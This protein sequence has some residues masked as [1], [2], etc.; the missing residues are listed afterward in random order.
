MKL[1]TGVL[2]LALGLH[3]AV[4]LE[5]A[6]KVQASSRSAALSFFGLDTEGTGRETRTLLRSGS[7]VT[8]QSGGTA[9]KFMKAIAGGHSAD[10]TLK[11][12]KGAEL[13]WQLS[14]SEGRLKCRFESR[15]QDSVPFELRFPFDP[16][17]TA[18]TLLASDWAADG[19]AAAPALLSAPDFGQLLLQTEGQPVRLRVYG[20]YAA[21]QVDVVIEG[22]CGPGQPSTISLTPWRLPQPRGVDKA[23]WEKVRR[24]W[25][26]GLQSLAD[27]GEDAWNLP[28]GR[29][30]VRKLHPPGMLG[31]EVISGNAT[32]STWFYADHVFWIP[33]LAPGVSAARMLRR[34]LDMTLDVR[35]EPS[36]RLVGY[37]MPTRVGAYADFLDSQP[38]VLIAAWDYVE[39]SG[40][41]DW[42]RKRIAQIERAAD[43][44]ASRD[45]NG[46][47]LVE[48]VQSGNNGA[49]IEPERGASW[50]DAVNSGWQDGYVNALTFRAW[51]CLADL[52]HRLGREKAAKHYRQLARRL[53]GAFARALW[54][55]SSGWLG[56]WRSKD[57]VLHDPAALLVNSMAVEYG[58]LDQKTSRRVL[59]R[60][61]AEL[62]RVGYKRF[63]LG[64]PA[65]LR[66][67][68]RE[69]YLQ[70]IPPGQSGAPALADGSDALGQYQNGGVHAGNALHWLAAHYR[71]GEG[72]YADAML[73]KMVDRQVDGLFQN[74]V[75]GQAGKGIEWTTWDGQP[76]GADGYLAD[77]F[78][79]LQAVFLREPTLRTR[80]YRPID[81][82]DATPE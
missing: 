77:N 36:G 79:F 14:W 28:A 76:S 73:R 33:Q 35:L 40:D 10:Y 38:S 69:E 60:L 39:A 22:R 23:I 53:K 26:G 18:T 6:I 54:S 61:R 8:L 72:E 3:D 78:R 21:R 56:W 31:N 4:A 1:A 17:T 51:C 71:I 68:R 62:A 20:N 25:F 74:G 50:W 48:A 70:G 58:L 29:T 11:T 43:Y 15:G 47:G 13:L 81:A 41:V 44:L 49:L 30:L 46:D 59:A 82:I 9:T 57:G 66:P 64:V 27:S 65:S 75:R 67:L 12:A 80:Y 5:P 63:D 32:C 19:S 55:E 37:W 7:E 52:E 24:G 34:T 2:V 42:L 45:V 16:H